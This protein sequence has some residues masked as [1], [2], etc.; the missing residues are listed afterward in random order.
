[1]RLNR[2]FSLFF[3]C[4]CTFANAQNYRATLVGTEQGLSQG[5]VYAMHKDTRGYIWIGTQDG[6]NRYDGTQVEVYRQKTGQ[7]GSIR[8]R[9]VNRIIESPRGDLWIGTED[10]LNLYHRTSNDFSQV[11]A[12]N[13]QGK[14]E[15]THITP[16]LATDNE[17]WYWSKSEGIVKYN[18]HTKSKAIIFKGLSFD[19]DHFVNQHDIF[20]DM[21][22]QLWMKANSGVVCLDTLSKKTHYYFSNNPRNEVGEPTTFIEVFRDRSG[23]IWLGTQN[24]FIRFNPDNR[25]FK[26]FF[27][28]NGR[29]LADV[30]NIVQTPDGLLWMA[31]QAAGLLQ[32]DP[33]TDRFQEIKYH[34]PGIPP[35]TPAF[36]LFTLGD[37]IVWV[38]IEPIGLLKLVPQGKNFLTVNYS[39]HRELVSNSIRCLA[40]HKQKI[41]VGTTVHGLYIYNPVTD[42]I[43]QNV[44]L[45]TLP[46]ETVWCFHEADNQDIWMG[47]GKGLVHYD[48]GINHFQAYPNTLHRH[49]RA[50]NANF[51]KHIDAYAE[52]KLLIATES[53]TYLFDTQSKRFSE[54]KA[55]EQQT[56]EFAIHL[57]TEEVAISVENKGIHIGR[58][59]NGVWE[60]KEHLVPQTH[61]LSLYEQSNLLWLGCADGLVKIDRQ[62]PAQKRLYT[63]R[64][65][66]A[67]SHVYGILLDKKGYFW[68]STNRGIL[69]FDSASNTFLNFKPSDG[70]Q[71]NEYNRNAYL[72]TSTGQM[73]FGGANGFN[74]FDPLRINPNRQP[75]KV[76]IWKVSFANAPSNTVYP[77]RQNQL[78][79]KPTQNSF[80]IDYA[81]IDYLSNGQNTYRYRLKGVDSTWI[82]ANQQTT[83]RFVQ[84]PAGHHTFEV[85]AAN[86]DGFRNPVPAGLQ[87]IIEPHFWETL[88]FRV[89]MILL[90]AAGTYGFYQY[91]IYAV[92]QQQ[93]K[94]MNV[95]VKTQEAE[96]RRFAQDLHD[97][98][99]ANLSA[100]K[101]VVGLI[102]DPASQPIKTKTE[103]LLNESL[104]DL[105]HLI[106]AMSP[107]SLERLGLVRAVREL[108]IIINQTNEVQVRL[109]AESFPENLPGEMQVNLY[110]I[111]QE[112]FQNALKHAEAG[113]ITLTLGRNSQNLILHYTDDGHGFDTTL[114]ANVGNGLANLR[115]RAQLLYATLTIQ[116]APEEG[117]AIYLEIPYSH[118]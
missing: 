41:W 49:D 111:I 73:Y 43:E 12:T 25:Q 113:Q 61:V 59:R 39:S 90:L 68:L 16:F 1:M 19:F 34:P 77:D 65:G 46:S 109:L 83:A 112:L 67:N 33:Y 2:C 107:R 18:H 24:G 89:A 99:G 82:E 85:Q 91:Q 54:I 13:A 42:R 78:V 48:A 97:G 50:L 92:Q 100:I 21:K 23:L 84:V 55:F 4:V 29:R 27:E 14:N 60:E 3:L 114:V 95:M 20:F 9:F 72:I 56:I 118:P 88:W 7:K 94:E 15:M 17:V 5:S 106:H 81:A 102:N 22:G 44:Y 30:H 74:Y 69:R 96:R 62:K 37:G 47:T 52:N 31:T 63:E 71:G 53:G 51:I 104:D 32:F 58:L 116:S 93:R 26:A 87:I 76:R 115:T 8:G 101:M 40:E 6:L 11:F 117:T 110:R 36:F 66:M 28:A 75:P 98:L 10:G 70:L 80:S 103:D 86:S 79:L 64:D 105:R 35:L 108:V 57:S 45:P 38:H